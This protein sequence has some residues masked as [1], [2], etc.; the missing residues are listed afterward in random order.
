MQRFSSLDA[1][2]NKMFTTYVEI[3]S[4]TLSLLSL[5]FEVC[6]NSD[7]DSWHQN[8]RKE[9]SYL[10]SNCLSR[11]FKNVTFNKCLFEV[12]GMLRDDHKTIATDVFLEIKNFI[13][14]ILWNWYNLIVNFEK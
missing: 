2:L 12:L 13:S 7:P 14:V 11:L 9:N 6:Y 3:L 10:K 5:L 8:Y 4:I 1:W